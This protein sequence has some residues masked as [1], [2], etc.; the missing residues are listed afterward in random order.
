MKRFIV[1]FMLACT[2]FAASL[3]A[4][5]IEGL[6]VWRMPSSFAGTLIMEVRSDGSIHA[7]FDYITSGKKSFGYIDGTIDGNNKMTGYFA[8]YDQNTGGHNGTMTGEFRTYDKSVYFKLDGARKYWEFPAWY[9]RQGGQADVDQ[10][11]AIVAELKTLV[12]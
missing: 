7:A 10:Y 11:E 1:F 2:V 5:S 6:H 8:L 9:V 3:T 4:Q 12:R